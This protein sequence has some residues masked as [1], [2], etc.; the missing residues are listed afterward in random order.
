[1]NIILNLKRRSRRSLVHFLLLLLLLVLL[2]YSFNVKMTR[3][4]ILKLLVPL[5]LLSLFLLSFTVQPY[6]IVLTGKEFKQSSTDDFPGWDEFGDS[7]S[8]H[9]SEDDLDPGSWQ[10]LFEPASP[11][12]ASGSSNTSTALEALYFS[13]VSKMVSVASSGDT[14]LMEE[15]AAEIENSA[16]GGHA[17]ARSVL[18]FLHGM[19]LMK[20]RNKAKS[21]MYHHFAAEGGN[22]QSQMALAYSYARQEVCSTLLCLTQIRCLGEL[23]VSVSKIIEVWFLNFILCSL[24]I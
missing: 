18:G 23:S 17:H 20:Q 3:C 1:M 10:P 8:P 24:F 21:V 6:T 7:D 11:S 14:R 5:I 16:S 19:G 15:A 4:A 22:M 13:G 12:H 2:L 9:K